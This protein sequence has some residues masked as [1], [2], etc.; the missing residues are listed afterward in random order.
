MCFHWWSL[1][2]RIIFDDKVIFWPLQ[3]LINSDPMIGCISTFY[4]KYEVSKVIFAV[5]AWLVLFRRIRLA[6][7]VMTMYPPVLSYFAISAWLVLIRCIR[8][9]CPI[10][11][12]PHGLSNFTVYAWLVLWGY[13][14]A[15]MYLHFVLFHY[16]DFF[17]FYSVHFY[18]ILFYSF[19]LF[20]YNL[21]YSNLLYS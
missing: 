10:S 16:Y 17:Q 15:L 1:K 4:W 9:A 5:S 8:L 13:D 7:P 14:G 18:L 6:C 20:Y 3:N 11:L 19:L 2:N 21:C 12:Y